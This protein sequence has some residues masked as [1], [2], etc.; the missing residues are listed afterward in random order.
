MELTKMAATLTLPSSVRR[1]S[2]STW[3][4]AQIWRIGDV[5]RIARGEQ[6]IRNWKLA[7]AIRHVRQK[8]LRDV[9]EPPNSS[10]ASTRHIETE[11]FRRHGISKE[12]GTF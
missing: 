11:Y 6:F 9:N 10:L 4:D 1:P 5:G 8:Y 12:R 3:L 7:E 2:L